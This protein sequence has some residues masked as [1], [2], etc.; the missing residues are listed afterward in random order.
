M[1]SDNEDAKPGRATITKLKGYGN[2]DDWSYLMQA[3]LEGL[4]RWEYVSDSANQRPG[5]K[6]AAIAKY[7][8]SIGKARINIAMHVNEEL[9]ASVQTITDPEELWTRLKELSLNQGDGATYVCLR[10]IMVWPADSSTRTFQEH[11]LNIRRGQGVSTK[12]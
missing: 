9:R 11:H 1:P 4:R 6:T 10:E 2:W 3:E 8:K 5:N 12:T 7:N